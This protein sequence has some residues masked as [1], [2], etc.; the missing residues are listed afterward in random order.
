MKFLTS[1]NGI[2]GDLLFLID[3]S[4]QSQPAHFLATENPEKGDIPSNQPNIILQIV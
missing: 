3:L 2:V 1:P 4:H